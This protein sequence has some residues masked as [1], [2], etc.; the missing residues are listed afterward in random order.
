[1]VAVGTTWISLST[2]GCEEQLQEEASSPGTTRAWLWE[3]ASQGSG[4]LARAPPQ[5][6]ARF[7]GG[8]RLSTS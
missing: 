7:K 5:L 1:M 6:S 3:A 8:H 4:S 2:V